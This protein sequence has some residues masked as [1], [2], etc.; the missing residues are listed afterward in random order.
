MGSSLTA[1]VSRGTGALW[2][3]RD[4]E[5]DEHQPDPECRDAYEAACWLYR[6][7]C[8]ALKPVLADNREHL[9]HRPRPES[10][11]RRPT[12]AV[13]VSAWARAGVTHGIR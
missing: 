3:C 10:R 8:F 4:F 6:D 13:P 2:P 5:P 7:G 11:W 12:G 1:V 9:A